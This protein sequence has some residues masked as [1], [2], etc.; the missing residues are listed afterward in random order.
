VLHDP[1]LQD[2]IH[3]YLTNRNRPLAVEHKYKSDLLL[4]IDR[5]VIINIH[6]YTGVCVYICMSMYMHIHVLFKA[7]KDDDVV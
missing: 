2:F 6:R 4:E 7:N 5:K 3:S 1:G